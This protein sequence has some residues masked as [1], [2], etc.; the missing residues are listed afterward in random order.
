MSGKN[1]PVALNPM[2]Q[3]G[4]V[5][6]RDKVLDCRRVGKQEV[7]QHMEMRDREERDI[8]LLT[9]VNYNASFTIM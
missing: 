2:Y 4:G 9:L 7:K 3:G 8:Q 5:H 6:I 1:A